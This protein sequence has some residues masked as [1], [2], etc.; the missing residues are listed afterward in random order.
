M[1]TCLNK[2]CLG[3]S[4][5]SIASNHCRCLQIYIC[6]S[7]SSTP[8]VL[9]HKHKHTRPR[10]S[11]RKSRAQGLRA[12]CRGLEIYCMSVTKNNSDHWVITALESG[13]R[14]GDH[15]SY[16]IGHGTRSTPFAYWA[17]CSANGSAAEESS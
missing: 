10:R 16:L 7:T 6:R 3:C 8:I 15:L 14:E 5:V 17:V 1:T 4:L 13:L 12:S 2:C 9:Q 11:P